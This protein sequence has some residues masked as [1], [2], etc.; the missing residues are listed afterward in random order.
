MSP[1]DLLNEVGRS[2]R[3]RVRVGVRVEGPTARICDW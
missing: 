3:S 2:W 1:E